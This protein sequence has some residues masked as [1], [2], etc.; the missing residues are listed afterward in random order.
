MR[1]PAMMRPPEAPPM[2]SREP[3]VQGTMS[4]NVYADDFAASVAFY[5]DVLGLEKSGDMGPDACFFFLGGRK[6]GLF[7]DGGY[8]RAPAD[9]KATRASF[10]LEVTSAGALFQ[11]LRE[12]GA[13][14]LH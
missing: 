7:L 4:V 11:R 1:Q 3:L 8:R 5:R 10:T 6:W 2:A 12:A 14:L 9:P 13:A